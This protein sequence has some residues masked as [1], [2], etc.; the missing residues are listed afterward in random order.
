MVFWS[1]LPILDVPIPP[2]DVNDVDVEEDIG[3]ILGLLY[4]KGFQS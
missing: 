2:L 4:I 1:I 3:F